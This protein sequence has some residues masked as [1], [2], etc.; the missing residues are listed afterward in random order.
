MVDMVENMLRIEARVVRATSG[1]SP[2]AL[3]S[4]HCGT[5]FD[6]V[7]AVC[8]FELFQTSSTSAAANGG[9]DRGLRFSQ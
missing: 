4:Y 9:S 5:F 7:S 2:H 3:P 6:N 8:L 1:D